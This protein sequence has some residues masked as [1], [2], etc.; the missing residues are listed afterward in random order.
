MLIRPKIYALSCAA[1]IS[2]LFLLIAIPTDQWIVIHATL[3]PLKFAYERVDG[4]FGLLQVRYSYNGG[5]NG[6]YS[7][8]Y[9]TCQ[10]DEDNQADV[11]FCLGVARA[12]RPTLGLAITGLALLV[13][14]VVSA[15]FH[16]KWLQH[17]SVRRYL[18]LRM[19]IVIGAL[20]I[21]FLLFIAAAVFARLRPRLVSTKD[22]VQDQGYSYSFFL[23]LT[24]ALLT[25]LSGLYAGLTNLEDVRR[26]PDGGG[27][28]YRDAQ[29]ML[30]VNR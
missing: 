26:E 22:S 30:L 6:S 4:Y 16:R 5:Q 8:P 20:S 29:A 12:A 27:G 2:V 1:V 3:N 13:L 23:F 15:I 9:A 11:D 7:H 24:A 21:G 19:L 10:T 14:L 17:A 28:D 25:F 18:D